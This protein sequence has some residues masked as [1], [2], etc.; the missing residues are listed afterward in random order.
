M[1]NTRRSRW[2]LKAND[3]E[4]AAIKRGKAT[5]EKGEGVRMSDQAFLRHCAI[6]HGNAMDILTRQL[7]VNDVLLDRVKLLEARLREFAENAT[8]SVAYMAAF[9]ETVPVEED[10]FR[11]LLKQ[12]ND[13]PE[14]VRQSAMERAAALVEDTPRQKRDWLNPAPVIPFELPKIVADG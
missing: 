7:A 11:A 13:A 5:L 10:D 4:Y 6:K 2:T 14:V 12:L 1:P 3:E 8:L 9:M